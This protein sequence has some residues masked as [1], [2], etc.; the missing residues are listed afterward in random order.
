[1]IKHHDYNKSVQ[2][3]KLVNPNERTFLKIICGKYANVG[4]EIEFFMLFF[5]II[6]CFEFI[7]KKEI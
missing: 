7:L 5:P 1:M 3:I 4:S 6:Q 2:V